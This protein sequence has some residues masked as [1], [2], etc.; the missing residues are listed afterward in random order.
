M[1]VFV[2]IVV[3]LWCFIVSKMG[4]FVFVVLICVLIFYGGFYFWVNQDLYVK[5]FDVLVVFV[6][7][8]EGVFVLIMGIELVNGDIVNYGEDVV[9]N[10]I[11]G[12]VFDWQWML[13]KEVVEVLCMGLVDFIVMILI[14]FFVVLIFVVG[15]DFYQVCIELEINDVNNYFVFLMGM[16]VVEK[17]CSFVVEMVG[18]EVVEC[19][20][21][22][23]SD[24]CD[25]FI[26]VMDGVLQFVDGVGFVV[27]GSLMFV[28]GIVQFVDG[29]VQFVVGVQ[30]FVFGVQQVSVGNWQFV[31]VVDC[32]GF[33]VQQ[34]MDVLLQVCIDIV[35]VLIEQGLIL[36]EIDQ[37]FVKFD[38]FGICLQEGN[39]Q[40][41]GIVGKVDQLVDGVVFFVVGV[42]DF[43]IGVGM[44]VLG[45]FVVNDG[46]VQLWDGLVIFV[47]GIVEL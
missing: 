42:F 25:K 21:M 44:V 39:V 1:K 18:S 31:D 45:V 7:D 32:V 10:F 37:V 15:D 33:V 27:F 34:V 40:V 5:F 2:M 38:F 16:Q 17:I 24:V 26:I 41:Q 9:E 43:V 30:M 6:V 35:N 23:F 46:V 29:I 12:N 4:I 22:G 28:D 11:E 8:D 20:F 3:E 13:E 19:L 14:D 47:F 36:E